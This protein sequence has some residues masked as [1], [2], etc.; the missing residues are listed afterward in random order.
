MLSKRWGNRHMQ[1]WRKRND[2]VVAKA[3]DYDLGAEGDKYP[4][5]YNFGDGVLDGEDITISDSEIAI[6]GFG[7][8]VNLDLENPYEDMHDIE[9]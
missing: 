4:P 8:S 7:Q 5:I 2:A 6:P 9:T 3:A 1:A